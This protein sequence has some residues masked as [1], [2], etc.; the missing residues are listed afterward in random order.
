MK[1]IFGDKDVL[2]VK[3]KKGEFQQFYFLFSRFLYSFPNK[4]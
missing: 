2:G 4:S 1:N 3:P